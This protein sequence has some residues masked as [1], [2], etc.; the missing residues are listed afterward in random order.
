MKKI[1]ILLLII[2]LLV[3]YNVFASESSSAFNYLTRSIG[4]KLYCS[5]YGTC[6][7]NTLTVGNLTVYGD[8]VNVSVVNY[9]ITGE[10]DLEGNL[11]VYGDLIVDRDGVEDST[12]VL[13]ADSNKDSC[14]NLTEGGAS[15]TGFQICNDGSGTNEFVIRNS[16][17][18]NEL[19]VIDRDTGVI[20]FYNDTVYHATLNVTGD[21]SG[22]ALNMSFIFGALGVGGMDMRGDPWYLGGVDL[23]IDQ[24]LL[25]GN[26][27]M[28]GNLDMNNNNITDVG[29]INFPDG[30]SICNDTIKDNLN[31]IGN[32]SVQG[33]FTVKNDTTLKNV[34]VQG[35]FIN[36]TDIWGIY[37]NGS[38]LYIG[39]VSGL[40]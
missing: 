40:V 6:N 10:L 13:L 37:D 21:L 26:I 38:I 25:V 15:K 11:S 9:N 34:T 19:I 35:R 22:Y 5:L 3:L 4:D 16:A 32:L 23:E 7:L 20:N 30:T 8:Y 36:L 1:W 14:I 27:S 2:I 12:L 39:N 17:T 29:C 24:N 33:D 31:I 18:G 28:D